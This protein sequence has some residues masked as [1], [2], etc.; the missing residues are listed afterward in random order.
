MDEEYRLNPGISALFIVLVLAIVNYAHE[1]LSSFGFYRSLHHHYPFYFAE[2]L[3]KVLGAFLCCVAIY[4]MHHIG[5]RRVFQELGLA[6]PILPAMAFAFLAS[7]PM[8]IGFALT[9]KAAPDLSVPPLLFLTVFSPLV[10][11]VEFRGFGFWQ[12]H[13]R[14]RWP[15]WLAI[16]PPAVLFGLGHVE[17]G[18]GWREV[19]GIFVLI[20]VGSAVFSWLLDQWQSLWAPFGLHC[21]MNLWWEVFSVSNTALGGWFP[22]AL[23]AATVALAI[24]LTWWAKRR[25]LLPARQ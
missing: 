25:G 14:A 8:L 15:F 19:A 17:K 23:V 10:E 3:D 11:E 22:F 20:A 21:F 2:S 5:W 4:A 18:Q 12:L 1:A 9:R 7:S 16:L 6:A 24:L 13:R